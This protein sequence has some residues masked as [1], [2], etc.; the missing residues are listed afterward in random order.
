[1]EATKGFDPYE[2]IGIIIP[3]TVITLLLA[4]EAPVFRS[5]LGSEGL[6]VGDFGLFVLVAFVFG[7]LVQAFGNLIELAV[8]PR[9]GLPTNLVLSQEQTLISLPQ[10]GTLQM[11]VAAM[12]GEASNLGSLNRPEWRA[13]TTR[14]YARVRSAGRSP[15]IDIA[16][17][18]Y[19]L[20]RGLVAALSV[21]LLWCVNAHWDQLGLLFALVGMIIAAIWRMA[22]VGW[23]LRL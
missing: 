6:T 3:G 7:H 12:E 20:C 14:A 8:W 19:G 9:C 4:S 16:N 11:C 18:T 23:K 17:R 10:R 15:R 1:M 22:P 5:M 13:I 2:I 21:V